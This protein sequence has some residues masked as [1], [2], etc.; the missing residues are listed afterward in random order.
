ML[1]HGEDE[2]R[3]LAGSRL[4]AREDVAAREGQRD[5]LGLDGRGLGVLFVGHRADERRGEPE[6]REGRG[7]GRG[8]WGGRPP[9]E[10]TCKFSCLT[11]SP[12]TKPPPPK[13]A[14]SPPQPL[15]CRLGASPFP[16]QT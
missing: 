5:H 1:E 13:W 3:R 8:R 4:R 15:P 7:R 6:R 14:P 11:Q 9:A 2:R 12:P 16:P 10:G